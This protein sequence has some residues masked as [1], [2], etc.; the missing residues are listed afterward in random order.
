VLAA[1]L[2]VG[3]TLGPASAAEGNKSA[4][5]AEAARP[6]RIVSLG[7]CADQ[8][9]LAMVGRERIAALSVYAADPYLSL[10]HELATGLPQTRG[11]TEELV[12][13]AP[14]LVLANPWGGSKALS[15]LERLG[16]PV[17]RLGQP[18]T[19]AE[20]D[21]EARRIAAALGEPERGER[22]IA[23]SHAA[24]AAV[25]ARAHG[26]P[27]NAAY[28][29]P[30]GYT[31]GRESFVDTVL[32]AAGIGNTAARMGKTGWTSLSLEELAVETPDALIFGFFH[33][34]HHTL[35]NRYRRHGLLTRLAA[36]KPVIDMPDRYWSCGGWFVHEAISYLATELGNRELG[37][38]E[39]GK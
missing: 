31:A 3:L 18:V 17:L 12:A 24:I 4:K 10:Y 23:R 15:A 2:V 6:M 19:L 8:Y 20:V 38:E 1:G 25:K 34:G 7:I 5:P 36:G 28:L 39:L 9:V 13:L 11:S 16:I 21:R 33:P 37:K 27:V 35:A 32:T 26:A 29:M 30:G 14:D 22:L